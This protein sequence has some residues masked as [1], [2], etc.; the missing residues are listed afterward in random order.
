MAAA[1]LVAFTH[2]YLPV[3]TSQKAV[4]KAQKI[5][6]FAE[7][8]RPGGPTVHWELRCIVDAWR[9]EGKTWEFHRWWRERR[10]ERDQLFQA[11]GIHQ[12]DCRPSLKSFTAL[13]PDQRHPTLERFIVNQ[14]VV[15]T[16]C[17]LALL[18]FYQGS[19]RKTSQKT[20]VQQVLRHVCH[21]A[22]KGDA[23][24]VNASPP[25]VGQAPRCC[26]PPLT[27]D[28]VCGH[29]HAAYSRFQSFGTMK[30]W[31][32]WELLCS[33]WRIALGGGCKFAECW[34]H[35]L[36]ASLTERLDASC[37]AGQWPVTPEGMELLRGK[38]RH[39]TFDP[40]VCTTLCSLA[41]GS[42]KRFRS[43]ARMARSGN[44]DVDEGVAR[45][46]EE[47]FM[48]AYF[49]SSFAAFDGAKKQF[50]VA[51]DA[52]TLGG[53]DTMKLAIW[54]PDNDLAAW[55]VPQALRGKSRGHQRQLTEVAVSEMLMP[56]LSA[57]FASSCVLAGLVLH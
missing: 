46:E 30:H 2:K 42:K 39:S 27:G 52:S 29:C 43:A 6:I 17:L 36:V 55:L 40:M 19:L 24:F 32:L 53:E 41:T 7:A 16:R 47:K 12:F 50:S 3:D 1:G 57:R 10:H 5:Y 9:F 22:L 44:M 31:R 37:E 26:K 14:P 51:L 35:S 48:A 23:A 13:S 4:L 49:D 25:P 8:A 21:M 56:K 38:K 11:M 28:D 15:S 20:A 33:L 18:L 54:S 45:K 34:V